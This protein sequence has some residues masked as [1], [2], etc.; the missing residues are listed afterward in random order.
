VLGLVPWVRRVERH[1]IPKRKWAHRG[2]RP[3]HP[4]PWAEARLLAAAGWQVLA[5]AVTAV[6]TE[7]TE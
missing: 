1:S 3:L 4:T 2:L 6:R 5:A 7:G